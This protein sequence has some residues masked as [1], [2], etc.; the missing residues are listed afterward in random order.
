MHKNSSMMYIYFYL[1]ICLLSYSF[2]QMLLNVHSQNMYFK[3]YSSSYKNPQQKNPNC[4]RNKSLLRSFL[5]YLFKLRNI[6]FR[7]SSFKRKII[8]M[9]NIFELKLLR[10]FY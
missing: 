7:M 8:L 6:V 9:K 10:E 1:F 5:C 3:K 2:M 4:Q